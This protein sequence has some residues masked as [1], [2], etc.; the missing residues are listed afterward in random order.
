M[1]LYSHIQHPYIHT[2]QF[3]EFEQK[4]A[5]SPAVPEHVMILG[6]LRCGN[7]F[8]LLEFLGSVPITT[9][10]LGSL[11]G[12]ARDNHYEFMIKCTRPDFIFEIF[13]MCVQLTIVGDIVQCSPNDPPTLSSPSHLP[14][15]TSDLFTDDASGG[16]LGLRPYDSDNDIDD[17]QNTFDVGS[18]PSQEDLNRRSA[19]RELIFNGRSYFV[20][21][22]RVPRLLEIGFSMAKN[23]ASTF[24]TLAMNQCSSLMSWCADAGAGLVESI[25]AGVG[26]L[27][28]SAM[29]KKYLG[30]VLRILVTTVS[31]VFLLGKKSNSISDYAAATVLYISACFP[32]GFEHLSKHFQTMF[33]GYTQAAPTD[34]IEYL[35][36]LLAIGGCAIVSLL[37][38][39]TTLTPSISSMGKVAASML[40]I[41]RLK[42]HVTM[43]KILGLLPSS[44]S[45]WLQ[46]DDINLTDGQRLVFLQNRVAQK[47]LAKAETAGGSS[48]MPFIR[49]YKELF[50]FTEKCANDPACAVPLKDLKASFAFL[51]SYHCYFASSRSSGKF[52][53]VGR[54]VP[55]WIYLFGSPGVGKSYVATD[56]AHNIQQKYYP[57]YTDFRNAIYTRTPKAFWDRY[58]SQPIVLLDDFLTDSSDTTILEMLSLVSCV[59]HMLD[60]ATI[61][62]SEIGIKGTSFDSEFIV[63]TSNFVS[64]TGIPALANLDAWNSRRRIMCE[65]VFTGYDPKK[66]SRFVIGSDKYDTYLTQGRL[67]MSKV[68]TYWSA[69]GFSETTIRVT[70]PYLGFKLY[71]SKSTS[72]CNKVPCL[73]Y[74]TFFARCCAEYEKIRDQDKKASTMTLADY[75]KL[76]SDIALEKA[77]PECE[78]ELSQH[79]PKKKHSPSVR[80]NTRCE[81]KN[82]TCAVQGVT[83]CSLELPPPSSAGPCDLDKLEELLDRRPEAALHPPGSYF[84]DMDRFEVSSELVPPPPLPT[85]ARCL[86]FFGMLIGG[87]TSAFAAYKI[88]SSY[89]SAPSDLSNPLDDVSPCA[90]RYGGPGSRKVRNPRPENFFHQRIVQTGGTNA[91]VHSMIAKNHGAFGIGSSWLGGFLGICNHSFIVPLHFFVNEKGVVEDGTKFLLS[92]AGGSPVSYYFKRSQMEMFPTKNTAFKDIVIYTEPTLPLFKDIRKFIPERKSAESLDVSFPMVFGFKVVEKHIVLSS[93]SF[94]VSKLEHITS[95]PFVSNTLSYDYDERWVFNNDGTLSGGDCG[96]ILSSRND[97]TNIFRGMFVATKSSYGYCVPLY[98][99]MFAN[100]KQ[101]SG[102]A[103]E[104][105]GIPSFLPDMGPCR[106]L[107]V[108]PPDLRPRLSEKSMLQESPLF[109][110]TSIGTPNVKFPAILSS[111]DPRCP[112][113]MSPLRNVAKYARVVNPIPTARVAKLGQWMSRTLSAHYPTLCRVLTLDEALNGI[114][115]VTGLERL[116]LSSTGGFGWV[117]KRPP[118]TLGKGFHYFVDPE[119]QHLSISDPELQESIDVLTRNSIAGI[120]SEDIYHIDYTKDEL[121]KEKKI[122]SVRTRIFSGEPQ[123]YLIVCKQFFGAFGKFVTDFHMDLPFK[124][125]MTVR[126]NEWDSMWKKAARVGNVGFDGD[127]FEFDASTHASLALEC[128]QAINR[129]YKAHDKDWKPEDDVARLTLIEQFYHGKH[130]AADMIYQ[131]EHGTPS[132]HFLTAILNS[133]ILLSYIHSAWLEQ[134]PDSSYEEMVDALWIAVYG[135]DSIVVVK[136]GVEFTLRIFKDY[137]STLNIVITPGDKSQDFDK[138]KTLSELSFLKH[139]TRMVGDVRFPIIETSTINGLLNW[140]RVPVGVTVAEAY[141]ERLVDALANVI[142]YED[143]D[144]FDEIH[145]KGTK[146]LCSSGDSNIGLPS[147]EEI[148]ETYITPNWAEDD[149]SRLRSHWD[150]N[151]AGWKQCADMSGGASILENSVQVAGPSIWQKVPVLY[152]PRV[153]MAAKKIDYTTITEKWF[154]VASYPWSTVDPIGTSLVSLRIPD[155]LIT[156]S[157]LKYP[158]ENMKYCRFKSVTVKATINGT[159]FHQGLVNM[160]YGPVISKSKGLIYPGTS[161]ILMTTLPYVDISANGN[162]SAQMEI[163][164]KHLEN[165]ID[166]LDSNDNDIKGSLGTLNLKVFNQLLT[167]VNATNTLYITLSIKFNDP[168]FLLPRPVPFTPLATRDRLVQC[169]AK[170]SK[171]DNIVNNNTII[172]GGGGNTVTHETVGD[173]LDAKGE[174]DVDLTNGTRM[175]YPNQ[176]MNPLKFY[177]TPAPNLNSCVGT[178]YGEK[179]TLYPKECAPTKKSDFG[180]EDDEMSI[181]YL[182]SKKTFVASFTWTTLDPAGTRLFGGFLLPAQYCVNFRPNP[183]VTQT[184][185]E[186]GIPVLDYITGLFNMYRMPKLIMTIKVVA[187]NFATGR[188]VIAPMYGDQDAIFTAGENDTQGFSL[189]SLEEKTR[190]FTFEFDF[191][192]NTNLKECTVTYGGKIAA[193]SMER[194]SVGTYA[195][196]VANQLAV[197]EGIPNSVDLNVYFSAPGIEFYYFA[198]RGIAPDSVTPALKSSNEVNSDDDMVLVQCSGD[199][200]VQSASLGDASSDAMK[201]AAPAIKLGEGADLGSIDHLER[202]GSLRDICKKMFFVPNGNVYQYQL[203]GRSYIAIDVLFWEASRMKLITN[204]YAG[205]RGGLRFITNFYPAGTVVHLPYAVGYVPGI[206]DPAIG[207]DYITMMGNQPYVSYGRSNQN[208]LLTTETSFTTKYNFLLTPTATNFF[209]TTTLIDPVVTTD[210]RDF[211]NTGYIVLLAKNSISG[212]IMMSGADDFRCGIFIGAANVDVTDHDADI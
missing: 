200:A 37:G 49:A 165:Y 96:Q 90:T 35:S 39:V 80:S 171:G 86:R 162:Q 140:V 88:Y 145:D 198:P 25:A 69:F 129:W 12:F 66:R 197:G 100:L 205:W 175:D 107:G 142:L 116:S 60:M 208:G 42:D 121:V 26:D 18:P 166:I 22:A 115:G 131:R 41:L 33:N 38:P 206:V 185:L 136:D 65:V 79:G 190:E 15:T 199:S 168:E 202:C 170:S 89:M 34:N 177:E 70:K 16:D 109:E 57:A 204:L 137:M 43:D 178:F 50:A 130:I 212:S 10:A 132:G 29:V 28:A 99:E 17:A 85:W 19:L 127:V 189:I 4:R 196:F 9:N 14:A 31:Y 83:E 210:Y 8:R 40:A 52:S 120:K 152:R 24:S 173:E 68:I 92:H 161:R 72:I 147:R 163:P 159:N 27:I 141:R 93:A 201:A 174:A 124:I 207:T 203:D 71:H 23:A 128:T 74:P 209:S 2:N 188:L 6:W 44:V 45:L 77:V 55:F 114:P 62:D 155:E 76:R 95:T 125:G 180:I 63:S 176:G 102:G 148:L 106:I 11:L 139:T 61:D 151:F 169:G 30:S 135:D 184:T 91:M 64:A 119:T 13:G 81:A 97:Q 149:V 111:K 160:S 112:P 164:W 105:D 78:D 150:P 187:S 21:S 192:S 67:D 56:L 1:K 75:E 181:N 73:T 36:T 84:K 98:R 195:V 191:A 144:L 122:L 118:G 133:M 126:S 82:C 186:A 101:T 48:P 94:T 134:F 113:G 158:F 153:S 58:K 156:N 20:D 194:F 183:G 157:Q 103:I 51:K 154:N 46:S 3:R 104:L 172:Y 117:H 182:C 110:E 108:C 59:D 193:T 53:E 7:A 123:Q 167:T 47:F 179:L 143:I 87:L 32:D 5:A 211:T 138:M 54:P 146:Y